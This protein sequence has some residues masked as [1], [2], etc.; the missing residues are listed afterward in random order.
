M[1]TSKIKTLVR[2]AA[3]NLSRNRMRTLVSLLAIGTGCAA[4]IINGGIVAD[5]F[6]ELREDAIYGRYGH[7]Q[8]YRSGYSVNHLRH[9]ESYLIPDSESRHIVTLSAQCPHVVGVTR[10]REFTGLVSFGGHDVPFVGLG[11]EPASDKSFSRNLTIR[12]GQGLS[13]SSPDG[14]IAGRGL[15]EKIGAVPGDSLTLMSLTSSGRFRTTSV[16]LEG[17]FEGGLKEYDDWTLKVPL[18]AATVLLLD[19]E[20]EQIVVLVDST[21]NVHMV[22]EELQ[23]S[24]RRNGL[25]V[26]V[27]TWDQLALFHNQ[28]V[29]LFGR[30]LNLITTIV[31][32]VVVL[33][34]GNSISISIAERGWEIACMRAIG[35]ESR[36]V[37]EML[38][39]EALLTGVVGGLLGVLLG[40]LLAWSISAIGIPFPSPPGS[41]RPFLGRVEIIG[42]TILLALGLSIAA[43]VCSSILPI[44]RALKYD[45]AEVL[46]R[47]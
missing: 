12:E 16:Q 15:A 46:R 30:E 9:P 6:R 40:I 32:V 13:P 34:I 42:S 41:T 8:I 21:I 24:F 47:G 20:T 25:N 11:V 33:G 3:R 1:T 23:S 28:V 4:L 31:C 14:V 19:N 43:V 2:L 29:S 27:K 10:R 26:E 44:R 38:V 17:I 7:L 18:P 39:T 37:G 36:Q 45:I 22:K 35:L 5:I